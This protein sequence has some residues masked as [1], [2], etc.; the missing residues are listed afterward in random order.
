MSNRERCS[1]PAMPKLGPSLLRPAVQLGPVF[2][3]HQYD[4]L[5]VCQ[6]IHCNASGCVEVILP[7]RLEELLRWLYW[8][9]EMSWTK[10][11]AGH[12]EYDA[13][14]RNLARAAYREGLRAYHKAVWPTVKGTLCGC[15]EPD[16]MCLLPKDHDGNH[17]TAAV[18]DL[19][20]LGLEVIKR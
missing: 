14:V 10:G 3:H 5:A 4:V 13:A 8:R 2:Q 19:E 15:H 12:E 11:I 6:E 17:I 18:K 9:A 1:N 20:V 16:T 7:E